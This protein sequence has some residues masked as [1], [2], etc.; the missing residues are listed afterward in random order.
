M[1]TY[2]HA[3]RQAGSLP[4]TQVGWHAYMYIIHSHAYVGI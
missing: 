2:L 3:Y 1:Y 4:A